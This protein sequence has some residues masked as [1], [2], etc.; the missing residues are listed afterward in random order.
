MQLYMGDLSPKTAWEMLKT[1]A[2]AFLID[3]RTQAEWSYV[4]IP[5][6]LPTGRKLISIEWKKLPDMKQN[7]DFAQ[8]LTKEVADKNSALIFICRTGGRSA[9]AAMAMT[10]FGFTNCF[11]LTD[12]FEGALDDNNHR[13]CLSGWKAEGLPWR[14]F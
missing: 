7:T 8:E 3:V 2:D 11:N 12:G 4:G 9:E 10:S 6:V 14:Q 1:R 5:N 13:G